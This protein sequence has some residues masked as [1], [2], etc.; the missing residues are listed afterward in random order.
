MFILI[1]RALLSSLIHF[2]DKYTSLI[3]LLKYYKFSDIISI[4]ILLGYINL[5]R[6]A[7]IRIKYDSYDTY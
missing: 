5:F 1:T 2:T 6:F 7:D 3:R 4:L